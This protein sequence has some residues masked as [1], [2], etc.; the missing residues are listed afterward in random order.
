MRVEPHPVANHKTP[1]FD[2]HIPGTLFF[3]AEVK[4]VLTGDPT[5]PIMWDTVYNN[6]TQDLHKA[7][8]QFDAV[9]SSRLV[10]NVLLWCPRDFRVN[11]STFYDLLVGKIVVG[12]K[13]IRDLSK[14]RYGRAKADLERIDLHILLD[15]QNTPALFFMP[16]DR[17]FQRELMRAFRYGT[18]LPHALELV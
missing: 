18:A 13:M 7:V 17:M 14:F 9:N 5:G 10:P 2:V 1:D 8:K 6:L 15:A 12:G 4:S 11:H 3:Y 16:L